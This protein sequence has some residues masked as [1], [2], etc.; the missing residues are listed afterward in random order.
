MALFFLSV[1]FVFI[2]VYFTYGKKIFKY[3]RSNLAKTPAYELNDGVDYDPA[4][5]LILF[6]HHF[7]S[8]AGAGPIVGPIIAGLAFGWLPALLW[9]VVGSIFVGGVHDLSALLASIANQGKS[10]AQIARTSLSKTAYLL[11][12]LFVLLSLIYVMI[13]FSD[14][15]AA[16]FIKNGGVATS[17]FIYILLAFVFGILRKKYRIKTSVLTLI[18]VPLVLVAVIGG[19]EIPLVLGQPGN[20]APL[21]IWIIIILVYAFSASVLPVWM[22]LQPRDYLSSYL[23]FFSILISMIGIL[24]GNHEISYQAFLG[25]NN[26]QL[27]GLFPMLFITIACGA[28]SGFH[29]LVASG[30]TAKQLNSENDA[31][32]VGYGSMLMEGV[33]AVIA[34]STV[35]ILSRS[36]ALTSAEPMVVYASGL[37]R[38]CG[39]IGIPEKIGFAFVY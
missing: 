39:L 23:L 10:V 28:C 4:P 33:V 3:F 36:D 5:A 1:V 20:F 17:S 6:G 32:I 22:L 13:V 24:F 29:S 8:I 25:W 30:T 12:L 38:F 21:Q 27:G 15:T 37:A 14:L 11:L 35:M 31:R 19:Q 9:I 18:F 7:S 34:L 2:F 26:S 16:T